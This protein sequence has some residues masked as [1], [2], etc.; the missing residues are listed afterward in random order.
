MNC[1]CAGNMQESRLINSFCVLRMCECKDV[2][3]ED[4][5]LELMRDAFIAGMT[6][7][8]I[9]QRLLENRELTFQ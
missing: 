9:R 7:V 3:T 2:S 6:S 8:P 4:Y 1:V 5:R